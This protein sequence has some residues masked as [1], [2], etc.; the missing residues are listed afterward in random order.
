[1][2]S[3]A[4]L[5]A[6]LY[7][8]LIGIDYYKP[9]QLY[10]SLKG[11]VR[12]INLVDTYI[13][14]TLQVSPDQIYRL[15]SPNLEDSASKRGAAQ[16]PDRLS[17][18]D[19][20]PTYENIVRAFQQITDRA[21]PGEQVYIHY[22]GHG[23]RARTVYPNL[24]G[25]N[26]LDEGLVPM[27][28]GDT[29]EGRYLRDVEMTTLLRRMTDKGLIVTLVLDSCHSGGATRGDLEI[30][31]GADLDTL[32]RTDE[33][34][35]ASREEL[36]RN[37]SEVTGN[38][39]IRVAGLPETREYVLIAACRP[40]EYA[41]EYAVNGQERNGAL[42]YWMMDTLKTLSGR[43]NYKTLHSRISAKVQSKFAQQVPMLLG[44]SD[45]AVFE[46]EMLPTQHAVTV[47]KVDANQQTLQ[48]NAGQAQGL[49]S[50]TLFAIY[51]LNTTDFTNKEAQI[52]IAEIT[53]VE[54]TSSFARILAETEGGIGIKGKVEQGAPATMLSA[55]TD[56]VRRVRLFDQKT[57]G[58][59]EHE[60]PTQALVE[61]QTEALNKVRQ[62][63]AGCGWVVEVQEGEESHFQVAIDRDGNY[64][65]CAGMPIS[66]LRPALTIQDSRAAEGVVNRLVHL[67]KYQSI[68]ELDNPES[69]LR[70]A[71]EFELLNKSLQA[72]SDPANPCLEPGTLVIMRIKNNSSTPLN[73]AVL[74]L[75]PTWEIS[76]IPLRGIEAPFYQIAPDEE[77]SARLRFAIPDGESYKQ[78]R[79]TLKLFATRGPADF[80]WLTLPSLDNELTRVKTRGTGS[81]ATPLGKL[82]EEIGEDADVPPPLT[83]AIYEPDASAEWLTKQIQISIRA[84]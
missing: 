60:L 76:Q 14:Q 35:V 82:L 79:E 2:E 3:R 9:N 13:R 51:P 81:S 62:S 46:A 41:Y 12:D 58:D 45:R 74:D 10:K 34:L 19:I 42:T 1:M 25:N 70:D 5:S 36:E 84:H 37:W 43:L 28:I 24:K 66:N 4:N 68:Q 39:S 15:T 27:D 17:T 32:E 69:E 54:A 49:T 72:F 18:K 64:E 83:R 78:V 44:E 67:A 38:S 55:P 63:L 16:E 8:L 50:R 30:R 56:L 73:I 29:P 80:R 31:S 26:Q 75:E 57:L 6:N 40:T 20:L 7:A 61:Q 48:L 52:A 33:S 65:I 53:E 59:A 71:I 77:V 23:G 22:S 47:M 11:C 21:K